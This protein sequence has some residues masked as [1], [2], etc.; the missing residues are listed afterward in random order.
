MC[1]S[2]GIN[3][4]ITSPRLIYKPFINKNNEIKSFS[5][6]EQSSC[7]I[8]SI[9]K[10]SWYCGNIKTYSNDRNYNSNSNDAK[11]QLLQIYGT[12]FAS[13]VAALDFDTN[14]NLVGAL[15]EYI[16][17]RSIIMVQNIISLLSG[18]F[19]TLP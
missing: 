7:C 18:M 3:M 12:W 1:R 19:Y 9:N 11:F 10:Y 17:S 16:S 4:I 14:M 15:C 6:D 2:H 13:N 5:Y 8:G